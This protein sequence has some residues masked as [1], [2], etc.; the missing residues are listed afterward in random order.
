MALRSAAHAKYQVPERRQQIR[1]RTG[2]SAAAYLPL[3]ENTHWPI[4][5]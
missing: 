5:N 4:A 2:L 1:Q 3:V